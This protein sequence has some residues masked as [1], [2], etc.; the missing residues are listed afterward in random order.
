MSQEHLNNIRAAGGN[1]I[2]DEA[3][4]NSAPAPTDT[5]TS[6]AVAPVTAQNSN[7]DTAIKLFR[8]PR[9]TLVMISLTASGRALGNPKHWSTCSHRIRQTVG[10]PIIPEKGRGTMDVR[11]ACVARRIHSVIAVSIFC[12]T[13]TTCAA[14]Q[15]RRTRSSE[16]SS[17]D[18]LRSFSTPGVSSTAK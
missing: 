4:A 11:T 18:W 13:S 1:E 9:T 7:I 14:T 5:K 6:P 10:V 8:F 12:S 2:A 17:R 16:I 3:N 15:K